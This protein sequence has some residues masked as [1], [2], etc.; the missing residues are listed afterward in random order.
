LNIL[1][2]A[3]QLAR[4]PGVLLVSSAAVYGQPDAV[5]V[6]EDATLSP[7]SPYGF[8]KL[9]QERLL[10]EFA[11]LYGLPVSIA[12]AFSTLGP[13][14]RHLA[15]WDI[16]RRALQGNFELPGTGKESRDYLYA[17]DVGQALATIVER[18]PFEGEVINVASGCETPIRRIAEAILSELGVTAQPVFRGSPLPGS[19]LRWCA[20][21]RRLGDLGFHAGFDIETALKLTV[22]WIRAHG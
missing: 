13:G 21:V 3:R 16:T 18:A 5:P 1:S 9:A 6:R 17:T 2:G 12:R 20:D 7:I 15:V 11:S 10:A 8:H 14:Q 4:A 19:P 22:S